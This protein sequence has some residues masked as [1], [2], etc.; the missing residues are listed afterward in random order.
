MGALRVGVT[1]LARTTLHPRGDLSIDTIRALACLALVSFHVVGNSSQSGMELPDDHWL[2]LVNLTFADMRM[3]LFSFLSGFVFVSLARTDKEPE[4]LL[5]SKARRLLVPMLCVGGLFW[6]ARDLSGHVQQ[7][8]LSIAIMPFA[9]FWFL[10]ATFLIMSVF[11]VLTWLSGRR[12][13]YVAALLMVLGA[14]AWITRAVPP[15]NVFSVIQALYLMPFF[16]AGYLTRCFGM[17]KIDRSWTAF[18]LAVLIGVGAL[19]ATDAVSVQPFWR[20]CLTV[21]CGLIFCFTLL[22]L[23]PKSVT[24]ARL[25]KMSYAIFL[26]HVFFTAAAQ[27]AW[28]VL[29]PD[30]SDP[31]MWISGIAV[32][33]IGPILVYHLI[34]S[35]ALISFGLLGIKIPSQRPVGATK[36]A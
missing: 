34:T 30:V 6:L 31:V 15:E 5:L 10:Q 14:G 36:S 28:L 24:L 19:L 8:V 32:G 11:V 27:A 20:R 4:E 1:V 16:M 2:R 12:D 25:G 33:V 21:A 22:S 23:Q 18:V 9:H 3:P 7:P 26:F 17:P 35:N 13:V 29:W